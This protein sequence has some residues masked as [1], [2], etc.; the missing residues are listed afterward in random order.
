[1]LIQLPKNNLQV[2]K[3]N[4]S[5]TR[6]SKENMQ[7]KQMIRHHKYHIRKGYLLTQNLRYTVHE[8]GMFFTCTRS[9]FQINSEC[10][11][12]QFCLKTDKL[13]KRGQ[14]LQFN[15]PS[16]L[17]SFQND[18]SF[19]W[20][21]A[22]SDQRNPAVQHTKRLDSACCIAGH[23]CPFR[24]V[25]H[26]GAITANLFI[27]LPTIHWNMF[28]TKQTIAIWHFN[29]QVCSN[30]NKC[31]IWKFWWVPSEMQMDKGGKQIIENCKNTQ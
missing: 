28:I 10:S 12:N 16:I 27:H 25:S 20:G 1:M 6:G 18:E 21:F 29:C 3:L 5:P 31:C 23:N 13:K 17:A 2:W 19:E 22:G 15:F 9:Y 4:Q 7:Q 26:S 8:Q 24:T 30:T 11:N 14:L